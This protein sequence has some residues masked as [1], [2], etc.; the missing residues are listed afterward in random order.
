[1]SEADSTDRKEKT[2]AYNRAY[3]QANKNYEHKRNREWHKRNPAKS[4]AIRDREYA[5]NKENHKARASR[6][7]HHDATYRANALARLRERRRVRRE[8]LDQLLTKSDCKE[9]GE[10][11]CRCLQFHHRDRTQKRIRVTCMMNSSE[12]TLQAELARCDILCCNCHRKADAK[13]EAQKQRGPKG[14]GHDAAQVF[15]AK[16]K[17]A[18][19]CSRCGERDVICLEFHH[20][21]ADLKNANVA[22]LVT[23]SLEV[24]V[25]ELL[26]CT[27]ICANC[28]S[29]LHAAERRLPPLVKKRK[30]RKFDAGH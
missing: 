25:A 13:I 27:V 19:G 11:D 3:Y 9:C 26:A 24:I 14:K 20:H 17:E 1:M 23:K 16:V 21:D 8:Y 10:N 12:K 28:H 7:Y 5:K 22:G 30:R 6:W 2:R 29:K 18:S 15:L 4:K